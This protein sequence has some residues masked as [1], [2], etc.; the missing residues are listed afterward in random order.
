VGLAHDW[1]A[2]KAIYL[3]AKKLI[4]NMTPI[5]LV[6][7]LPGHQGTSDAKPALGN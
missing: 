4:W 6:S 7:A 1:R 5:S 3:V 2:P